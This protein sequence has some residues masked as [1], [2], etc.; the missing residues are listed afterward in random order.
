MLLRILL[1]T[2]LI[3]PV[4]SWALYKPLRVLAPQWNRVSCISDEVCLELPEKRR[5]QMR[6]TGN[7]WILLMRP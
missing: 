1:L 6:Y 2:L 3:V 4:V 5:K 7:R